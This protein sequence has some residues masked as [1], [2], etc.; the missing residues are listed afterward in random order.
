ME[1]NITQEEINE[2]IM[3]IKEEERLMSI[4]LRGFK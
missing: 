2:E 3:K 4:N 1:F